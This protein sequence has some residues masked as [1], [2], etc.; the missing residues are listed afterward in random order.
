MIGKGDLTKDQITGLEGV[1]VSITSY[2]YGCRRIGLQPRE[3]VNGALVETTLFDEP[4]LEVI[5]SGF[6][7]PKD[8]HGIHPK[9]YRGCRVKDKITGLEGIVMA[10]TTYLY[11]EEIVSLQPSK[12]KDGKTADWTGLSIDR[13]EVLG[14]DFCHIIN[15]PEPLPKAKKPGGTA[16]WVPPSRSDNMRR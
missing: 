12:A 15:P 9:D 6:I 10:Q 13:I 8:N 14:N 7:F 4:Q 5:Q 2:L 1:V 16:H 11:G 3:L